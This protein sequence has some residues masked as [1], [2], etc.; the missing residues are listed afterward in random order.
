[1][2]LYQ[3]FR[4]A[5]K[6]GQP[7]A[8]GTGMVNGVTGRGPHPEKETGRRSRT[9]CVLA[10]VITAAVAAPGAARADGFVA[11]GHRRQTIYHSPE[12]PGFTSWVGAWGMP[13]GSLMCSFTQATGPLRDRPQAP[14]DVRQKLSWP[15]EGAPG[16]DMTGLALKNVHLRSRDAGKTWEQVSADAFRS[17]MDGVTGEAETA[18][19]D[20][21]VLRGV[22]GYYLPYD[23]EVPRTGYLQ[24]SGDGT[25]TWGKPEVLLDP[26]KYTAWPKRIRVLRDGR[27]VIVGGLARVP[28]N[29][30]T[31]AEYNALFE[32]LLLVSGDKGKTWAGPVPV[33]LEEQRRNWGG[34]EFDAAE[35]AGGDLLCVFRRLDPGRKGHEVRWQGVLKKAGDTWLP[36]KAGPSSLAHGGHPELL[37]TREG[38]VLHF[39]PGGVHWT[40]DAGRTWNRLNVPGTGY[41]P[42]SVQAADGRI[43][44]FGHVGGDDAY[45]KVDQSIV[46]DTFRLEKK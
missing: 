10:V 8:A 39:A 1:M 16:Y 30:R 21:T 5:L 32:P 36:A 37:A 18:L 46:M 35:L 25:L 14:K 11:V 6:Q 40:T 45:G 13:D 12:R 15:P 42:R 41:Y 3:S 2:R 26:R 7:A 31:R 28:A 4:C 24:R 34:E 17:C 33:V 38:P 22:W 29:S 27:L 44:V 9:P 23:P 19:A 43:F 20:G